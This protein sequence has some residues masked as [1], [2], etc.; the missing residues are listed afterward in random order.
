[1]K[2]RKQGK[3]VEA[4]EKQKKKWGW[5]CDKQ[6]NIYDGGCAKLCVAYKTL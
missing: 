1:M 6:L 5:S 3:K 4:K 2:Y